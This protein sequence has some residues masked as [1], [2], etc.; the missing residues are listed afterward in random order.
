MTHDYVIL[1]RLLN[2]RQQ[3]LVY[4]LGRP[5]RSGYP[6]TEWKVNQIVQDPWRLQLPSDTQ[7]GPYEL[8]IALFDAA[9][10]TEVARARLGTITVLPAVTQ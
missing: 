2:N 5:V 8:E 9:S 7:P 6:T 4:W 1:L 10:E 3:E